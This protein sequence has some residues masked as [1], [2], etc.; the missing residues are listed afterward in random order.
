MT[1][2]TFKLALV[3]ALSLSLGAACADEGHEHGGDF[4]IA[5][6][7]AGQLAVEFGADEPIPLPAVSGL[8]DG[9]AADEPGFANLAKDEP[10]EGLFALSGSSIIVLELISIDPALKFWTPGLRR[11]D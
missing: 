2:R 5:R 7:A 11:F 9:W 1:S 6:T 4:M 3:L 8:L 10:D